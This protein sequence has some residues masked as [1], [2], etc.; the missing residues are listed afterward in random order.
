MTEIKAHINNGCFLIILLTFVAPLLTF[1]E[2][3]LEAENA[4]M[5][6]LQAESDARRD[7]DKDISEFT[8]FVTG[9]GS[10]FAG[11]M[12]WM[13]ITPTLFADYPDAPEAVFGLCLTVS[14][15]SGSFFPMLIKHYNNP[16]HPPIERLMGKHPEYI[17]VY[18]EVYSKKSRSRRLTEA[19]AGAALGCT[20]ISVWAASTFLPYVMAFRPD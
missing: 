5:L 6:R 7:M 9:L 10:A 16:P 15:G 4:D 8:P 1:A 19:S 14:V 2:T 17:K 12:I 18:I 11:G 3:P 20:I 13:M